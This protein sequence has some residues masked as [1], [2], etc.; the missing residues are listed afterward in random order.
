[1]N[2]PSRN[3]L[4]GW[5]ELL[6]LPN[7]PTVPG[8]PLAGYLLAAAA[9][10]N[11]T[12]GWRAPGAAILVALCLYACGLLLNDVADFDEDSR[13]RPGRPLPSGRVGRGSATVAAAL[14]AAIAVAL[15]FRISATSGVVA[16]AL[17]AAILLYTF[18]ARRRSCVGMAIMGLCRGL[19]VLLGA[20]AVD[21]SPWHCL[22]A[23]VAALVTALYITALSAI[24]SRET[25]TEHVGP[26]RYA[27]A[28]AGATGMA[29]GL[30][31]VG[32]ISYLALFFGIV[33]VLRGCVNARRLRGTPPPAVVAATIG[34]FIRDM[35]LVQAAF[36]AMAP[37][38][39]WAAV[40]VA[41][42]WPLSRALARGFYGS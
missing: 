42:M 36:C 7:L 32:Q 28:A 6:R 40:A 1:V 9:A 16:C 15:A 29:A 19:S 37:G 33:L 8:D 13:D 17:L 20:S 23:V 31:A 2:G 27:P 39:L 24:A 5:L 14:A 12:T 26:K 4:R 38:G 41:A 11:V 35:T 18:P 34:G 21:A 3:R 30:A 22:P 10:G 25:E